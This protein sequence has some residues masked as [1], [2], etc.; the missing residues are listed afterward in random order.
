MEATI[1]TKVQTKIREEV[2]N[3]FRKVK[4][5]FKSVVSD[6]FTIKASDR[7]Q[8]D[9]RASVYELTDEEI[10]KFVNEALSN[11]NFLKS[12]YSF[13]NIKENVYLKNY[14]ENT[15]EALEVLRIVILS[16]AKNLK[17]LSSWNTRV[18]ETINEIEM[19]LT[20]YNPSINKCVTDISDISI[21][22]I[23]IIIGNP[24]KDYNQEESK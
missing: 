2:T 11:F 23:K 13:S 4:S 1:D 21:A 17:I 22:W 24:K 14:L 7:N 3:M 5:F 10:F 19:T 18:I 6:F 12:S 20:P 8:N 16:R 9:W 15:H